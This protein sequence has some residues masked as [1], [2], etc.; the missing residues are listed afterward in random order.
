MLGDPYWWSNAYQ[1]LSGVAPGARLHPAVLDFYLTQEWYT[2]AQEAGPANC[3]AFYLN[4]STV[5][6][7]VSST[8]QHTLRKQLL[9]PDQ[10]IVKQCPVLFIQGHDD[11][12]NVLALLDYMVNKVF[13]FGQFGRSANDTL[14]TS[15]NHSQLWKGIADQFG[16]PTE[17]EEPSAF[18]LDW[19]QVCKQ[20]TPAD[21]NTH[22]PLGG[23]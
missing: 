7:I 1:E 17:D 6:G 22:L 23:I 11:G 3:A 9:L 13:L 16:W 19:V 12:P 8:L 5:H 20:F 2:M 10:G 15:W 18:Q 21:N 14:Y 4:R